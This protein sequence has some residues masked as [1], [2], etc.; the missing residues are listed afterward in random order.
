MIECDDDAGKDA[1]KPG[2]DTNK[3]FHGGNKKV[4]VHL[5]FHR[6]RLIISI[7]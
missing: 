5:F 1:R 2:I 6:R 7:F 3:S 4:G